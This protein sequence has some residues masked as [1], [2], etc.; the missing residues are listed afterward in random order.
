MFVTNIKDTTAQHITDIYKK[1]WDIEVFFKFLKQVLNF[2]HLTNRSE[3][4]IQ[5]MLY[6]TMIAAILLEAY[7]KTNKLTGFKIPMQ[8][9]DQDLEK[10]ITKSIV[11]LCGGNPDTFDD[12]FGNKSP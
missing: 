12:L 3:N 8:L 5:V 4:G 1:R 11:I 9:L 2:N 7:K 10:E 6:V